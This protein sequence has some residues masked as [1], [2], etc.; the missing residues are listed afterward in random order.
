MV[1]ITD[2]KNS[3]H[4]VLSR[5]VSHEVGCVIVWSEN[6]LVI[7]KLSTGNFVNIFGEFC[8]D[9]KEAL[10]IKPSIRNT[11][12]VDDFV[13]STLQ[14]FVDSSLRDTLIHVESSIIELKI[15]YENDKSAL[16]C[17][18]DNLQ[19]QNVKLNDDF[20]K[21]KERMNN[22][23]NQLN[24]ARTA[25]NKLN[26]SLACVKSELKSVS[27]KQVDLASKN[28]NTTETMR[29]ANSK[30]KEL[31][32]VIENN[33]TAISK[34]ETRIFKVS[35]VANETKTR[36]NSEAARITNVSDIRSTGI[37]GL[38]I[39]VLLLSDQLK[40]VN[41]AIE[42][43]Q[44]KVNPSMTSTSELRGR[45]VNVEKNF[46]ASKREVMT[47]AAAAVQTAD[48]YV[49]IVPLDSPIRS[50]TSHASTAC[51]ILPAHD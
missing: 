21:Q 16:L 20:N 49:S 11:S 38:K 1:D 42:D 33:T 28:S 7:L 12:S 41:T 18:I 13:T 22:I 30:I 36:L 27:L 14:L 32:F 4:F 46:Q 19:K 5:V 35:V 10:N 17:K 47:Y 25:N 3:Q 24:L 45:V 39:K 26:D 43:F 50:E 31:E 29:S 40:D 34:C 8:D 2:F 6:F 44:I 37:C 48:K 9:L 23:Q 15:A 51:P